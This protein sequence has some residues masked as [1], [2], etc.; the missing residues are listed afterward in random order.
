MK[1]R[2][3]FFFALLFTLAIFPQEEGQTFLSL[4]DTGVEEFIKLHPEYDGRGTIIIVLDTG[5]DMGIDG[6]LKTSTGEVKVID[7]QDFTGQGDMP[8]VEANLTSKDGKDFFENTDKS[9]SVFADK[10]KMLK[11]A[12]DVYWMSV[13][14]ETHLLN[15]GSGAQDLNGNG[16][17]DD[18]YFMVTYK[19]TEGYWVVYFDTNGNGDLS[20]EKPLR[21]YK[22]NFDAFTIKNQKGLTPLTMALNI[23]PDE[24]II[25]LFFD[26]GSHGT[27]CAGIAA[28]YNIGDAGINGVAPGA[29]VIGIKLGN[30][31]YPGGATVTES[32]KK[33][34][35]YADKISKEMKTPC[36]VSMSFG[37]GSEIEARSEIEK[38]LAELLSKNPYLYVSTSNG[39]EGPGISTS[40]LPS[41][42]SFVFS[43]GAVLTDEIAR[44][45]Y[46]NILPK[47]I[48][49]HFSSRGGEVSK[50]DIISP[51]A[52]TSTVPNFSMGDR[53]W[54]TSMACPYT[55]GVMALLLSAAEKEFPGVKIPSQL[56]YKIIREGAVKWTDYTILDQGAGYIN[57]MNAYD[58]LK[59]YLKNNE[60]SKFETYTVSSFA[61]NQ[62]DNK[63]RNLYIRD[64]SFL[65]GD[66]VFAFNIKRE[67]TI[68]S[69]KFYRVFNL[70]S[71]AEWLRLVQKKVYI[72]ND[73]FANVNVKVDKSKIKEPGLY[74]AQIT[75]YRDDASK[76]P[77]FNMI[78]TVV[79]PFEFNSTNN[80]KMQWKD[81]VVQQGMIKRYF[82]SLPAGQNSMKITLS[83]DASSNKYS[84]CRYF[85]HNNN[86]IQVDI[87]SVLYS[88]NRDEKIENYYY[89]LEPGVYEIDID[90]FFLA[91]EPSTYNLAVEFLSIHTVDSKEVSSTDKRIEV[92]NYFNEVKTYNIDA[93][94]FGYQRKYNLTVDGNGT[95]KMPFTL[96]KGEASKEFSFEMTKEDYGKVT[97]FAIQ[98]LDENG[99]AL[100]KS[101]LSYRSGGNLSIEMPKNKE[102][103]DYTL[104]IIPAFAHKE[105]SANLSVEE[106]TFLP[107]PQTVSVKHSGRALLTLYPNSIKYIDIDFSKPELTIPADAEGYGK[108]YFKSPTTE[109]AEYE[110]PIN[111]KF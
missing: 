48:L 34:Y 40:G 96:N 101:G 79:I 18:K 59:K 35:L 61:P 57:V 78:A 3:L 95:Y 76:T 73:Q 87:S 27:H 92:V 84:R 19:T 1:T 14:N 17:K 82:V 43:S 41:S 110:L 109:K 67:N 20:D 42:S 56:L 28:G 31:N 83:R 62:P 6:L 36:I 11:S 55:S 77:E 102:T 8:I 26:D 89:D 81:Q 44:D 91:A 23:F 99:K 86:G 80:F 9:Y 65:T 21:N 39:N 69:D 12:D 68:K 93:E 4:K 98:I 100:S 37:I 32:M 46:G 50:P 104:E 33:A 10:S 71:D 24:K 53:M 30:N 64:G 63:S 25:S 51:G 90:G 108:I 94:M 103:A 74:T 22:E 66:E 70:K 47:D 75:A 72:R 88:V 7:V 105:L 85:L 54:G 111:F 29:K 49:L 106:I 58:V 97:D 45:N 60:I 15:S 38:F 13:L 2:L 5:V 107:E 16:V 52:A